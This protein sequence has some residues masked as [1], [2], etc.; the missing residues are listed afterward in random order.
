MD[1]GYH[2]IMVFE[3]SAEKAGLKMDRDGSQ[4]LGGSVQS[5]LQVGTIH[6]YRGKKVQWKRSIQSSLLELRTKII[7]ERQG[8][9]N[10]AG[11]I[12]L[13]DPCPIG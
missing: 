6:R 5:K 1:R 7:T 13:Q 4:K 8:K 9:K 2:D 11:Q 3:L 12:R 10:K